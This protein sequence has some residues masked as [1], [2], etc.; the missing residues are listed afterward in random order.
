MVV[1]GGDNETKG[2]NMNNMSHCTSGNYEVGS[3]DFAGRERIGYVKGIYIDGS[4]I[5][6][7]PLVF[8]VAFSNLRY[9]KL[10]HLCT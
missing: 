6:C 10:W 7:R 4:N 2:S 8:R 3:L 1:G 5:F 9:G